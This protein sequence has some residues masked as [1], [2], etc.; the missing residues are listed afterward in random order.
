METIPYY[1]PVCACVYRELSAIWSLIV[2]TVY[3]SPLGLLSIM[4]FQANLVCLMLAM[5]T[6][7]LSNPL[8]QPSGVHP[9]TLEGESNSFMKQPRLGRRQVPGYPFIDRF[10]KEHRAAR[11]TAT[12]PSHET[13][14]QK[15]T[16]PEFSWVYTANGPLLFPVGKEKPGQDTAGNQPGSPGIAS[17]QPESIPSPSSPAESEAHKARI[18]KLRRLSSPPGTAM[19]WLHRDTTGVQSG[20]LGMS[21][22]QQDSTTSTPTLAKSEAHKDGNKDL[23]RLNSP[24]GTATSHYRDS[25][26]NQQGA[27][28]MPS[29]QQEGITSSPIPAEVTA[30]VDKLKK[31]KKLKIPW[32][33]WTR[34]QA[35]SDMEENDPNTFSAAHLANPHKVSNSPSSSQFCGAGSVCTAITIAGEGNS[36]Q[37]LLPQGLRDLPPAATNHESRHSY[38]VY[39]SSPEQSGT[40]SEPRRPTASNEAR[41]KY[42]KWSEMLHFTR[43]MAP[44][45][46]R[47]D[48]SQ[49]DSEVNT[50]PGGPA[51]IVT[52]S[53]VCGPSSVC[54]S[55]VIAN[56]NDNNLQVPAVVAFPHPK[57]EQVRPPRGNLTPPPPPYTQR[58]PSRAGS[59]APETMNEG[60]NNETPI[61][62]LA[63]NGVLQRDP[64]PIHGGSSNPYLQRRQMEG[65]QLEGGT[66]PAG[67]GSLVAAQASARAPLSYATNNQRCG[68]G[69]VCNSILI[70]NGNSN[71]VH[72]PPQRNTAANHKQARLQSLQS[73]ASYQQGGSPILPEQTVF[74]PT[75]DTYSQPQAGS[76]FGAQQPFTPVPGVPGSNRASMKKTHRGLH[77]SEKLTLPRRQ[78]LPRSL[79]QEPSNPA[80]AEAGP[81]PGGPS[82]PSSENLVRSSS[83][84][85]PPIYKFSR[86]YGGSY[87]TGRPRY[88]FWPDGTVGSGNYRPPVYKKNPYG[89][90][91]RLSRRMMPW[92]RTRTTETAH[93][94][95]QT[96]E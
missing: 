79:A 78:V 22:S 88:V 11:S 72:S 17:S 44:H 75:R 3:A 48:P 58:R 60:R 19:S 31:L 25:A 12:I 89:S 6:V 27:S 40:T 74:Q 1:S 81:P 46:S 54:N 90:Q 53:Q 50:V 80:M 86:S 43:R 18:K 33:Y 35:P 70:A 34:R 77:S 32:H 21:S 24:P 59:E 95:E 55:H 65:G 23:S 39:S 13:P 57:A 67:L 41:K 52:K 82:N 62:G 14:S 96:A 91:D 93:A 8:A 71:T 84:T 2:Q 61:N 47:A 56:R 38:P 94:P 9:S 30:H 87:P 5:T 64:S 26:G 68:D 49:G 4:H 45:T 37:G 42:H 15:H 83:A 10:V 63:G 73:D 20:S 16:K 76:P 51:N 69:G 85:A 66:D 92:F 29:S 7:V 36:I 28:G